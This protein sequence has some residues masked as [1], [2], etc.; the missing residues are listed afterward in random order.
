MTPKQSGAKKQHT[1]AI[2]CNRR[3]CI[4]DFANIAYHAGSGMTEIVHINMNTAAHLF[5]GDP[6]VFT[7]A[8]S[9]ISFAR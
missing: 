8:L 5:I 2:D 9:S 1:A 4:K 7:K 3:S 6:N